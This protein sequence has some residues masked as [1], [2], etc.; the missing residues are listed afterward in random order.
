MHKALF[1][2]FI[3]AF[4]ATGCQ[5]S[6]SSS[7]EKDIFPEEKDIS[8]LEASVFVPTLE[9]PIEK[10]KNAIYSAS[11]LMAWEEI[12]QVIQEPFVK[13][14]SKELERMNQSES[15]QGVLQED[16]YQSEVK[17]GAGSIEAKAQFSLSLPFYEPLEKSDDPLMFAGKPV[18]GFG[19]VGEN[20]VVRIE[21]YNND[22][23]FAI[24][25]RPKDEEHEI[26]LVM[27]KFDRKMTLGKEVKKWQQRATVFEDLFT[28]ESQWRYGFGEEDE[29]RVPSI[30]FNLSSEYP[31]IL[32]SLFSTSTNE[33]VVDEC[34]QRTAFILNEKGAEIESEAA[35]GQ[36]SEAKVENSDP[37]QPKKLI[38]DQPYLIFLKR[39]DSNNPYFA[40]YVDNPE[41]MEVVDGT[42]QDKNEE[43]PE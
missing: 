35:M 29:L 41:L 4:L 33:F 19:V 20:P 15:Y 23:D 13:F 3:A 18:A 7:S 26:I 10:G 2:L 42:S 37:P 27:K 38:F 12:K 25:L 5:Q 16:E 28:Y 32:N 14:E 40:M 30:A 31:D 6:S 22:R 21:Y 34:Y 36:K 24:R 1:F 17:V 9:T 39:S 8:E 11:L 43:S